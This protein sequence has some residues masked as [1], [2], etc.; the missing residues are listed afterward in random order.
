ML[1]TSS[2]GKRKDDSMNDKVQWSS[3]EFTVYQHGGTEWHSVAGI[4]I[5]AGPNSANQWIALYV[6]QCDSFADRIPSHE[7]WAAAVRLGATRVHAMAVPL[8][9]SRD[10]IEA[11]LIR[12][13]QPRLNT[14][15][16]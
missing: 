14:Q 13:F 5:F 1:V 7:Q 16:R 4:Y 11:E 12:T 3:H 2:V 15:L 10:R 8:A 9:A 6:G